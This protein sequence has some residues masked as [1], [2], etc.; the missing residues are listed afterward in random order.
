MFGQDG[1]SFVHPSVLKLLQ[2][3]YSY[4]QDRQHLPSM[5]SELAFSPLVQVN[6]L[7]LAFAVVHFSRPM[8]IFRPCHLSR[9]A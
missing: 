1:L 2:D 6:A 9:A 5:S 7:S 8:C 4:R 3:S